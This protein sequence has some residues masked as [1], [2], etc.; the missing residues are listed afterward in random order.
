MTQPI[1]EPLGREDVARAIE[2]R[3]PSRIPMVLARWWGQGLWEEYGERLHELDARYPS[4]VEHLWLWPIR[5]ECMG[6]SWSLEATGGLDSRAVIDDWAK[7]DEFIEKLPR[8][9]TDEALR[10]L[11]AIAAKARSDGR[12]I[13]M[14]WWN[15]FFEKPWTLRG[16]ENLMVDYH[17]NPDEIHRLHKALLDTYLAYLEWGMREFDFDGFFTSDDLGHQ[18]QL[19]MSPTTFRELIVPYYKPIGDLLK[20]RGKHFWLHSCGN[21]TDALDG[22]AAAGLNVF[23]PVQKHTM[24]EVE[25]ARKYRG[26]LAFLVGFDVQRTLRVGTPEEVRAEV[27]HL[28]D[29]FDFPEGGM[30]LAAGNGIVAGTPFENI[31]AFLEESALYGK[32]HRDR[33]A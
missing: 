24:D 21:N 14:G 22:L 17:E 25:I 19:M 30:L 6:L 31:E 2:G 7:L 23:H 13:L 33:F 8:P 4:D 1:H 9:E 10:D 12:Y 11:P 32:A 27:R 5:P 18:T 28:I 15:L 3:K 20:G 26:K 29:T 16:M